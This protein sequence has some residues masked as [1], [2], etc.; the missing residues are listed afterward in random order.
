VLVQPFLIGEG[1]MEMRDGDP[2]C[3][4]IFDRHYSRYVYAD[5]RKPKLILGP[6]EKMVLM[7]ADGAA[8]FGWRK[9]ISDSGETGVNCA[10]F[11]N[12]GD[13][14]SSD[15]ILEAEQ[16][17]RARWPSERFY[18][19]VDPRKVKPTMVRGLPV[20]GFCFMKAGWKFCGVTKSG[21]F[22]LEKCNEQ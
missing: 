5:G 19:Y 8:L 21:K 11:R 20:F 16:M 6:G 1:W 4:A 2:S 13:E 7:R 3:R 9:F 14:R 22:I 18:T 12:E 17:A 15:L 10:I